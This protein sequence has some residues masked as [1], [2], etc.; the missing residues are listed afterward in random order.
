MRI[1]T[2]DEI[3]DQAGAILATTGKEATTLFITE[4]LLRALSDSLYPRFREVDGEVRLVNKY[5]H[6]TS[7][8][9]TINT[10]GGSLKVVI[11]GGEDSWEIL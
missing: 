7:T 10:I 8:I 11:K 1:P 5:G 9:E 2:I 3:N 6:E 4:R